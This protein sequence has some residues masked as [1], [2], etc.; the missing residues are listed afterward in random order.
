MTADGVDSKNGNTGTGLVPRITLAE[1]HNL[2]ADQP[3]C[4]WWGASVTRIGNGS[5]TV[6]LPSGPDLLRSG[7]MLHGACYELVADLA[8][9]LAI[10]TRTGIEPMAVTIEMK[11]SFLRGTASDI[12]GTA[13]VLRVGRRVAFGEA[14]MYDDDAHLV[15]HSSLSYIRPPAA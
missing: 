3:F 14:E 8:M 7:V 13:R 10:M 1:A 5:A 9:W 15:A 2:L 4:R 11:T 6:R 12:V